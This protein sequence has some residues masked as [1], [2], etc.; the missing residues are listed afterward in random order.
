MKIL[1]F[2]DSLGAGGAQRQLVGLASLLYEKG[3]D[4]VV[5]TYHGN[6]D[7]YK[8]FLEE[9]GIRN[10]VIPDA[11]DSKKRIFAVRR[12]FLSENAEWVIAYQEIP[13]LIAC[14]VK[15]LGCKSK[16]LVSERN[17]TQSM[18]LKEHLR[19]FLYRYADA[20]VPNSY[21]QTDF[22]ISRYPWMKTKI[23][24]IVNFV[25][26]DVFKYFQH[27]RKNTPE[28][29]IVASL[30][31]SKNVEGIIAACEL[32]KKRN[33]KFHV[34]WYGISGVL[35]DY[36]QEL[37]R[38]THDLGVSDVLQFF[39][40]T[41]NIVEEY[42]NASFLCLPSYFEGTPNVICEAIASGLPVICSNVCDNHKYVQSGVNG[43]LFDPYK[44][45][46]IADKIQNALSLSAEDYLVFQEN[47][48]SIAEKSF[49]QELFIE[50]YENI[51]NYD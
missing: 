33:C 22:L 4:V 27:E 9:K 32:L 16:V 7:F 44:P 11:V 3:Y 45:S 17:T 24:T 39:E 35:T 25:D 36:Q 6:L 2:T 20:I 19:F 49:S 10:V 23:K 48:R 47:G 8:Q 21:T 1:L 13:S 18:A 42:R 43:F 51:L 41:K 40:K 29:L 50:S 37:I 14:V 28:I 34:S 38:I 31:K 15:I 5:C 30:M 26:I 12:F 46:D